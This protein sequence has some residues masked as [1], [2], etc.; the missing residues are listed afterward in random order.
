MLVFYLKENFSFRVIAAGVSATNSALQYFVNLTQ[1]PALRQS[2]NFLIREYLQSN[3]HYFLA[4]IL[5]KLICFLNSCK[6]RQLPTYALG[7]H[8]GNNN[9]NSHRRAPPERNWNKNP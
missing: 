8:Y 5:E 7:V 1:V 3:R 6:V 4:K 9:R 2:T